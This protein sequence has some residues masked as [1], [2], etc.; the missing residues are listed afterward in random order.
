MCG[1]T[2][3]I[4][5]QRAVSVSCSAHDIRIPRLT[6]WPARFLET[7]WCALASATLSVKAVATSASEQTSGRSCA[8]MWRSK[9]L[10]SKQRHAF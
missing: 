3:V 10:K 8:L 1:V 7:G 5:L 9:I 4:A 2:G 6:S